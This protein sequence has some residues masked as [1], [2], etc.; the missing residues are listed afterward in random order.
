MLTYSATQVC[1]IQTSVSRIALAFKKVEQWAY[2]NGMVFDPT[3]F[4]AI[5]FS[6]K[7]NPFNLDIKL[8]TL[9]IAQDPM[10]TRIVKP[11]PKDSSIR[12]LGVYYDARLSRR[13]VAGPK[14]LENT[15]QGVETK[16]I[17]RAVQAC[18]LPILTYAAPA[19]WPGRTRLNKHRKTIRSGVEG[20]LTRLDKVQN[21]A[22]HTILPVWG[23]TSIQIMQQE[24]AHSSNKAYPR[25][26][27]NWNLDTP[28]V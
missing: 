17:R 3:K 25:P 15:I 23:T 9:P 28:F 26:C 24:A 4:E 21:I 18:I 6:R 8:P 27:I 7:R 2:D 10:V 1:T 11:T 22:L 19:W 5:H 13:A 16:V 14:M 12:W 20:Q